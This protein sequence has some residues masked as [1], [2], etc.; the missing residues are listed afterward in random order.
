MCRQFPTLVCL[1]VLSISCGC[2]KDVGE[3]IRTVM[4]QD[5]EAHK[6]VWLPDVE[7]YS[8]PWATDAAA[9]MNQIDTS[10]CPV[11]FQD[12]YAAHC[13]TWDKR[14]VAEAQHVEL[15]L[16]RQRRSLTRAE[17]QNG[18]YSDHLAHLSNTRLLGMLLRSQTNLEQTRLAVAASW[19]KFEALAREYGVNP[20]E[21]GQD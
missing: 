5:A 10:R 16:E 15:V 8:D 4:C 11:A 12:A 3:E 19:E 9:K 1:L 21:C 18:K 17:A 7:E 20:T 6:E 2:E 13:K 14:G